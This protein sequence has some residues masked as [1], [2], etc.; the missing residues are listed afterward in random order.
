MLGTFL[1]TISGFAPPPVERSAAVTLRALNYSTVPE[2]YSSTTRYQVPRYPGTA[3]YTLILLI[4]EL[5]LLAAAR[6][7]L[8]DDV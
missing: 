2:L 6:R 4:P 3:V 5:S 1:H 8:Y 7:S